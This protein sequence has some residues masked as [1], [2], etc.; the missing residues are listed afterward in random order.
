MKLVGWL[1]GREGGGKEWKMDGWHVHRC[2]GSCSWLIPRRHRYLW[3][4]SGP[5]CRF[6]FKQLV[7]VSVSKKPLTIWQT[8]TLSG[9]FYVWIYYQ[10]M[11]VVV[12]KLSADCPVCV[13]F[14]LLLIRKHDSLIKPRKFQ[15]HTG[16][17]LQ[18]MRRSVI[19]QLSYSNAFMQ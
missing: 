1:E 7:T 10:S 5:L 19:N 9:I 4:L 14:Y 17:F 6:H 15:L 3:F 8:V 11:A 12:S 18:R 2:L 16:S 13:F